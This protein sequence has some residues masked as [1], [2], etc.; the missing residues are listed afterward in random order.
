MRIPASRL[1]TAVVSIALVSLGAACQGEDAGEYDAPAD[2]VASSDATI[3]EPV[4][5]GVEP[6][7]SSTYDLAIAN[8]MP[9]A[10]IVTVEYTG[11]GETELGTVP[12]GGEQSFTVAA[13]AGE[14][15]T[16]VA[17]DEAGTH[18]PSTTMALP[19]GQTETAWTIE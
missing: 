9:H 14:T 3:D 5:S 19:E 10:M 11:G 15:V 13:S 4:S 8:P 6:G 18:S 16:L 1:S 2:T 12:A 7:V 17:T